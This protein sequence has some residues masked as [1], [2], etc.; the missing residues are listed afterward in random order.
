MNSPEDEIPLPSIGVLSEEE[1]AKQLR[2]DMCRQY[3]QGMKELRDKLITAK[4]AIHAAHGLIAPLGNQVMPSVIA[5]REAT[6]I[7]RNAL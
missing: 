7:L 6:S 5:I 1:S 2:E 3:V 4:A